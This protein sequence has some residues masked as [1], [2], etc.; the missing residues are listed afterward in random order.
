MTHAHLQRSIRLALKDGRCDRR[1]ADGLNAKRRAMGLP[2]VDLAGVHTPAERRV[3][4]RK[5][6]SNYETMAA[7]AVAHADASVARARRGR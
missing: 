3:R 6:V 5:I 2:V 4:L 7:N 1:T